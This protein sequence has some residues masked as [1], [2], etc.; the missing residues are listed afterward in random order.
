MIV[1]R[2]CWESR[3]RAAAMMSL[4]PTTREGHREIAAAHRLARRRSGLLTMLARNWRH[5][6]IAA[7][8]NARDETITIPPVA[9]RFAQRRDMDAQGTLVDKRV[10]PDAVDQLVLQDGF[11]G[12]FNQ[13]DQDLERPT[14]QP[15]RA[16]L[17]EQQV[18][19]R[20]KP[21]WP[22]DEDRV[23]HRTRPVC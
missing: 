2:R 20:M 6:A 5:E 12:T 21:K 11:A 23:V 15:Y 13:G 19:R 10:G 9:Q 4:R 7:T 18:F 16:L 22:K 8:R 14:T 3:D 17:L 1:S